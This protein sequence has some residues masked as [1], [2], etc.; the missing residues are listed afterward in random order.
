MLHA[1]YDVPARAWT[2]WN[3]RSTLHVGS[4]TIGVIRRIDLPT[5][6]FWNRTYSWSF[7]MR[8]LSRD[9]TTW[10]DEGLRGGMGE[11]AGD[12]GGDAAV[13]EHLMSLS[14]GNDRVALLTCD[15]EPPLFGEPAPSRPPPDGRVLYATLVSGDG[16]SLGD[17]TRFFFNRIVDGRLRARDIISVMRAQ[18]YAKRAADTDG[19]SLAIIFGNLDEIVYAPDD[20]VLL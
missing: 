10:R 11:E 6:R 15:P 16:K 4:R 7:T 1:D 2:H 5:I 18:Q 13:Y 17:V 19:T 12:G 3:G 8:S 14:D 9:A 20:F